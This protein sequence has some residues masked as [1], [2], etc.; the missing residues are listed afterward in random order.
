MY[1]CAKNQAAEFGSFLGAYFVPVKL[2][3]LLHLLDSCAVQVDLQFACAHP[4]TAPPETTSVRTK[5]PTA[6]QG[7][8]ATS[9]MRPAPL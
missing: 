3:L 1:V 8:I 5:H 9:H 6:D 2:S 4:L 7:K